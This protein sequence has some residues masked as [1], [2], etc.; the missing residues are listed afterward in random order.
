[1][2]NITLDRKDTIF[3]TNVILNILLKM[4]RFVLLYVIVMLI[5]KSISK[6][7]I[8]SVNLS[9]EFKYFNILWGGWKGR[10]MNVYVAVP[11]G[12]VNWLLN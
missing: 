2:W 7:C 10:Y 6:S 1:L 12:I 4:L 3:E 11:I 5:F 8:S 9:L